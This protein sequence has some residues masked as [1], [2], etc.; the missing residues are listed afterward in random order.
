MLNK[1]AWGWF[2]TETGEGHSHT[3]DDDN[4]CDECGETMETHPFEPSSPNHLLCDIC[5]NHESAQWH[6]RD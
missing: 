3:F 5:L 2:D 4:Y 1:G 6:R